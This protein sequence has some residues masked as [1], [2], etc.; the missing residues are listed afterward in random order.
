[1]LE[2]G[3]TPWRLLL[4]STILTLTVFTKY[5]AFAVLPPVLLAL[6][7]AY[8]VRLVVSRK[9]LVLSIVAALSL[10]LLTLAG[11]IGSNLSHYHNALPWNVSMYDPSAHRPRD[12]GGINFLSF[13]PWQ[14]LSMPMLAPGKLHSFW[15]MI[16]SGMWFDTE[17]YFLSFLD[18]NDPWWQSYTSW[19]RGE[20]T[21]PGKNPSLSLITRSSAAGLILLGLV[22]LTLLLL[23][24]FLCVSGK[25]KRLFELNPAQR[26][27]MSLFPVLVGFNIAGI[28]ALTM[29][30]P[31]YNAIKPSY[32]LNSM[33]AFIVFIALGVTFLEKNKILRGAVLVTSV[34]LF[35]IV[36]V[37]V[38]HI[39]FSINA[40]MTQPG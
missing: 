35:V 26:A 16:Y 33:S 32:F 8:G 27:S 21:F 6:V 13:E 40:L 25:W 9:Q 36:T 38:L 15:T 39:V 29:R 11:Y 34:A 7:W 1:V 3:V 10:P 28:I 22:P 20:G 5:T 19:Y 37:H 12:P 23:G 18:R 2:R 14:D 30:L 31:V 24:C 17:P 4:L